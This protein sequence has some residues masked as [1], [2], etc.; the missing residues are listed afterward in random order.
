MPYPLP[1]NEGERLAALHELGILDT[2]PEERFD[3]ITRLAQ[4]VFDVPISLISLIDSDR[5]WLKSAQGVNIRETAREHAF[6]AHAIIQEKTLFVPNATQDE[7]FRENPYVTGEPGIRMYAGHP[8]E[9]GNGLR[10]G[11][12]CVLDTKP[13]QLTEREL[14]ILSLLA[15]WAKTELA[16]TRVTKNLKLL[17]LQAEQTG[18]KIASQDK[19]YDFFNNLHLIDTDLRL[20]N[21]LYL[22]LYLAQ[23]TARLRLTNHTIAVIAIGVDRLDLYERTHGPATTASAL[24]VLAEAVADAPKWPRSMVFRYSREKLVVVLP[25]RNREQAVEVAKQ[26]EDAVHMA[27]HKGENRH[28]SPLTISCGVSSVAAARDEVKQLLARALSA[29]ETAQ[30]Q[31][32]SRIRYSDFAPENP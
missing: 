10:I 24:R 3:R 14:E 28:L 20:P 32:Q 29:L 6:C 9:I 22:Q 18:K 12:V 7:R 21:A 26:I 23:E 11:T 15:E 5:Q 13:R 31:G 2:P 27:F 25:Q 19:L 1:E 16:L 8:I 4:L 30:K 17:E